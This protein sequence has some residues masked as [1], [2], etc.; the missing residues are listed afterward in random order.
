MRLYERD[1]LPP[2][3]ILKLYLAP[4]IKNVNIICYNVISRV[5]FLLFRQHLQEI[6]ELFLP[7]KRLRK[8]KEKVPEL[9]LPNSKNSSDTLTF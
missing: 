6:S 2:Y 4:Y 3:V 8:K 7:K 9:F 1:P 5:F